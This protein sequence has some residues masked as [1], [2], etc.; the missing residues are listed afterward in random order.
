MVKYFGCRFDELFE[1]VLVNP[2]MKAEQVLHPQ[3]H[4]PRT[5]MN[6]LQ[7]VASLI[8][9]LA[10]PALVLVLVLV[11]RASL[12]TLLA[13]DVKR[14]KAGPAGLEVEFQEIIPGIREEVQKGRLQKERQGSHYPEAELPRG[15]RAEML[16]LAR[17]S[18]RAAILESFARVE[19]RLHKLL[20]DAGVSVNEFAGASGRSLADVAAKKGLITEGSLMAIAGLSVLRNLS[21]HAREADSLSLERATE[22]I[23]LADAVLYTIR[24]Q[25]KSK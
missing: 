14:W 16:E 6:G 20:T 2:E 19:A 15:F 7:F 18:P 4:D 3:G 17:V 25:P 21:A 1:I 10:W 9:S 5:S 11:F 24:D 22:F 12:S 23:D 8:G 13:G